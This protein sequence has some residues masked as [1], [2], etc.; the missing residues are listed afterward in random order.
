M[1][2]SR[3]NP[4]N[5]EEIYSLPV[6]IFLKAKKEMARLSQ[7]IAVLEQKLPN[8]QEALL[9]LRDT[10]NHI[11]IVLTELE[12][13]QPDAKQKRLELSQK[14]TLLTK[15]FRVL[16]AQFN[17]DFATY[18]SMI[19]D[20]NDL[21]V[22]SE[23]CID[24]EELFTT[25]LELFTQ[26]VSQQKD[27]GA[28]K[29]MQPPQMGTFNERLVGGIYIAEQTNKALGGPQIRKPPVLPS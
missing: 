22:I 2:E 26:H 27:G 17:E 11:A 19:K 23:A 21:G 14:L 25:E 5:I 10:I 6:E 20:H 3:P 29:D 15:E 12:S 4:I 13:T 24:L 8:K 7:G 1:R 18:E 28:K 9:G 16:H